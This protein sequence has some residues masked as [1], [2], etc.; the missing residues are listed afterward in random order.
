[1]CGRAHA[2]RATA[3]AASA[4]PADEGGDLPTSALCATAWVRFPSGF[5]PILSHIAGRTP[6]IDLKSTCPEYVLLLP[7]A[8]AGALDGRPWHVHYYFR[9]A[10]APQS[11]MR[12]MRALSS[13]FA[14]ALRRKVLMGAFGMSVFSKLNA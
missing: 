11:C 10:L 12:S 13:Y 14:Q 6:Q 9:A 5:E 4:P 3:P 1:M 2:A 8:E 7:S